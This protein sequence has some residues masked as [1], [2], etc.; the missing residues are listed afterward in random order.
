M[1]ANHRQRN[2]RNMVPHIRRAQQTSNLLHPLVYYLHHR[3]LFVP[4]LAV[5]RRNLHLVDVLLDLSGALLQALVGCAEEIGEEADERLFVGAGLRLLA[6]A[7]DPELQVGVFKVPTV[8]P[9]D[10]TVVPVPGQYETET[11][12]PLWQSHASARVEAVFLGALAWI[13]R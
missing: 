3:L 12:T 8:D 1:V 11:Q 9:D 6:V 10:A 4:L 13:L 2:R 7:V 5:E